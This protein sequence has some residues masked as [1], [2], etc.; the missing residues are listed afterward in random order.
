[1]ADTQVYGTMCTDIG[2]AAIA[3]SVLT[4]TKINFAQIVVGDGG[5][6]PYVPISSQT[7]LKHQVWSGA[8]AEVAQDPQQANRMILHA[9]LPSSVGGWVMR[10]IGVQDD[11]GR[12]IAIGNTPEIP[13]E[14]VTS[15]A[16]MEMDLYIYISVVDARGINVIIDP[17]VV[18]A[19]KA[20]INKLWVAVDKLAQSVKIGDNLYT[21][22]NAIITLPQ[23]DSTHD[24]YMSTTQ[25]AQ[26]NTVATGGAAGQVLAWGSSGQPQWKQNHYVFTATLPTSG[27]TG[28][29]PYT[30]TVSVP[31]L[32][33][34][35]HPV[36]DLVQS[37]T[38]ET[39][40]AQ[41]DA[42]ACISR[43]TTA[44]GSL[45]AICYDDKPDTDITVQ[46]EAV[47]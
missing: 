5:G 13:K 12:L 15:G 42:Y 30:Q 22:A 11:K 16:I 8:I 4:G 21:A 32:T 9:V 1:M 39:A 36:M 43:A 6:A 24:G 38:V 40:Q 44:D 33:A 2:N 19:S 28:D 35:M 31:G 23:A 25:A 18:I 7:A 14:V 27:W 47:V 26:L 37:D 34:A 41:L 20:D 3:N 46:L 45:T 29:G 10:E 17:T